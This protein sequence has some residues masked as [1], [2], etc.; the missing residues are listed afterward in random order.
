MM[1]TSRR[2]FADP[3]ITAE[4]TGID[5]ELIAR[6]STM[7]QVINCGAEIDS[8]KFDSY[9]YKTAE[10]FIEKYSWY[11]MPVRF[12]KFFCTIKKS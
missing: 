11:C 4:I 8:R 6:F 9:A 2:F 10:I 1:D 3:K 12:I 5:E 7:L